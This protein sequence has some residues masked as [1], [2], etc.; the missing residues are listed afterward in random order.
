MKSYWD[1]T[2]GQRD[3]VS[4]DPKVVAALDDAYTAA[5]TAAAACA[6]ARAAHDAARAGAIERLFKKGKL[7]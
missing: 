2:P 7:K 3:E 4:A 1:L 5:A 6:A